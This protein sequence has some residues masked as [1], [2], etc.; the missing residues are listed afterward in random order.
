MKLFAII[1]LLFVSSTSSAQVCQFSPLIMGGFFGPQYYNLIIQTENREHRCKA[2]EYIKSEERSMDLECNSLEKHAEGLDR[3]GNV[4][5]VLRYT[6]PAVSVRFFQAQ[7]T[8]PKSATLS[9]VDANGGA[10]ACTK[11][12]ELPRFTL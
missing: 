3:S 7:N 11:V 5:Y 4:N 1:T 10:I 12:D 2:F 9:I 6:G 8:G